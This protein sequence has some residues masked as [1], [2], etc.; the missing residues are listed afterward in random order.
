MCFEGTGEF[1]FGDHGAAFRSA[2]VSPHGD[3]LPVTGLS[4]PVVSVWPLF[5][6]SAQSSQLA[7]FIHVASQALGHLNMQRGVLVPESW[8][9]PLTYMH[10]DLEQV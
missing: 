4:G 6:S 1:C 3:S 2:P 8:P 10:C 5:S 7:S 9:L